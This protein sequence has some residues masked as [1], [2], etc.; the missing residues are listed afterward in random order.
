MGRRTNI[1]TALSIISFTLVAAAAHADITIEER[2][3]LQGSGVM[4][5]ANMNGSSRT[6][7][8]GKNARTESELQMQSRLVRMFARD[9]ATAEIVRLNDD[10]VYE[11]DMK[12]KSYTETSLAARRAQLDKILEQQRQAQAQQQQTS[13]GVDESQC[14]W[15][16]PKVDVIRTG[17]KNTFAGF[18]AE[19]VTVSAVQ[20]CKVKNSD[21]ICDFGLALDQWVAPK[22]E[23]DSEALAYYRAYAE[24]MGMNA[25]SS[26]DFSER[27]EAMFGRYKDMW[28]EVAEKM[29][30]IKGYPVK[31]SFGFGMGGPQCQD[32][33]QA[34]ANQNQPTSGVGGIT[35]QIGGAI[36]GLFGKKKKESAP[37]EQA[38]APATLPNGLI[39]L[40]TLSSELVSV[41]HESVSP[42]TFEVPADF[43]QVVSKE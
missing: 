18:D 39:P 21:Q 2:I 31:S 19:R 28:K 35:G 17:E 29:R 25:S 30:D 42:Q 5:M 6:A 12:K 14:E 41:S 9:N 37:A 32:A 13:S 33:K 22:F 10:K 43:K 3:S 23:G 40:M 8:S 36:G 38:A 7:I 20:S 1:N 15:L 4:S 34:Q 11:L 24:K 16:P 27:A 26:R